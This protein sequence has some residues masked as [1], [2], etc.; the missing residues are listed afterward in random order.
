MFNEIREIFAD[1]YIR[2]FSKKIRPFSLVWWFIKIFYCVIAI[3]FVYL[4][5]C[6]IWML[7][8]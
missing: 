1:D 5:Y 6:A 4:F 7:G 8:I 3:S 2:I